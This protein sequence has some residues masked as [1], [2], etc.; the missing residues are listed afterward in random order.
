MTT[1]AQK[2]PQETREI[3][4]IESEEQWLSL[5]VPDLTSTMISGLVDASPYCTPF[6]IY[7]AKK[8]NLH[9]PFEKNER[10]K[11]GNRGEQYCAQE[12][13]EKTGWPIRKIDEYIRIP[14]E[15]MGSSFDY[16]IQHPEKGWGIL[17]LKM[18]DFFQYKEKFS[19]E[20]CPPHI[21]I[22]LQHQLECADRYS[23]GMIAVFTGIYDYIPY[24]RDRDYQ[25]GK[26]LRA[27][28]KKFWA[29]VDA[30]NEP[31]IDYY[32]DSEVLSLLYKDA[33]GEPVD[34]TGDIELEAAIAKHVRLGNEIKMMTEDRDA[35][36]AEI[37]RRLENAGGAYTDRFKVTTGWTKDFEGT[38]V[39][40]EMVGTKIGARK[41][42]RQ[43]LTK[44][45]MSNSKKRGEKL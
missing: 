45:L 38:T 9:V 42:Y 37:H 19:E 31:K 40:P 17:E 36:K 20:E 6:E 41:G 12:V 3:I 11:K 23:W 13:S 22:Q 43:C 4:P 16:E 39:T 14:D 44:D 32:R 35:A 7:H 29:D 28:A 1:T 27:V 25:M 15:R 30:G 21:E 8:S 18:V 5:R 33:G 10:V 24:I 26:N 34:K 2:L